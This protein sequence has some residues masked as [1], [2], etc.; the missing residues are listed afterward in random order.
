MLEIQYSSLESADDL[1]LVMLEGF[2]KELSPFKIKDKPMTKISDSAHLLDFL[3]D[4]IVLKAEQKDEITEV[5]DQ[6]EAMQPEEVH[7]DDTK[8][9]FS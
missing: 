1:L 6:G 2:C 8:R 5:D 9:L 7:S 4:K 3:H